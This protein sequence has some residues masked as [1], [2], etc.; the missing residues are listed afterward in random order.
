MI[1][2]EKR[3]KLKDGREALFRSPCEDDAEEML[4]FIIR[5]SGETDYL[6]KFPEEYADF[7]LEQEKAFICDAYNDRDACNDPDRMMILCEV[8]GKLA[9][10]CLISFCTGMKDRHRA[11]AAIALLQEFWGLGIGTKMFEE[12]FR[13]AEDRGG[14]RQIELD[15][16][17]AEDRGGI[18]Q[19]ELDFIEG[20]ARAR[21]LYEKMGFR[22]TG[23]KPDAI[24]MKDGSFVNEYMMIKRL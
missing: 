11:S 23:V 14:I 5:A 9:G 8:R 3:C 10:N 24:R 15:F 4:R 21:G 12:L 17:T 20:N 19:I 13:T 1:F 7:T 2:E 6:M 16:R 22:I 18:R